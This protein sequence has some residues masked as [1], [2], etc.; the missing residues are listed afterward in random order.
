MVCPVGGLFADR[1]RMTGGRR[2]SLLIT[3]MWI[4]FGAVALTIVLHS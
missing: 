1:A 4:G 3:L 2:R